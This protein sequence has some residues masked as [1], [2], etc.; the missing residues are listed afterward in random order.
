MASV[1]KFSNQ[2]VVNQLR[3]IERTIA[4]PKNTDIIPD[5]E[6][7][8]YSLIP[9]RGISSYEY[10][11]QRKAEL[12]CYNRKDV[13]V[14]AGWIVTA[15][16][17]LFPHQ[18]EHFF[19]IVHNFLCERY[20][21]KNCIQSI[22]HAD[23]S[24]QPHLHFC[25]IPVAPDLKHGGEKICASEVLTQSELRNFHP[26]L[27]KYLN[28]NGLNIKILTG[29]TKAQGGNRTVSEMKLEREQIYSM[30]LCRERW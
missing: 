4:S 25:F 15:P 29:T 1:K 7:L 26:A 14:L 17:T 10:F 13:K 19:K 16:K 11:K 24:G 12:Y 3:H 30:D 8:N 2:A 9:S 22:V 18:Q 28:E 20:G 5:R 6:Y 23:E 27:E 21:T